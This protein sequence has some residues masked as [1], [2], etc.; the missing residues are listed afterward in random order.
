MGARLPTDGPWRLVAAAAFAAASAIAQ[1]QQAAADADV[2]RGAYLARIGGCAGC[3]TAPKGGAPFA[4]GRVVPSPIGGIFS[5]NI[6]PDRQHGIGDYELQDFERALRA[7][8]ARGGKHLYPAMPYPSYARMSDADVRALFAY[9]RTA[10]APV[11]LPAPR[12]ALPFPFDQRWILRWWKVAFVP[13]GAPALRPDRDAEWQRGAY[14]V[15]TVGHC[16]TCHTPRGLAYQELGYDDT[17]SRYL[18]GAVNDHWLS[19][20]LRA[21]PGAGLARI[22]VRDVASF[23]RTG[24]AAGLVAYGPM[25]DEVEQS[26]QH[27]SASDAM[28]MAR[29]LKSL[30]SQDAQGH[31]AAP[32]GSDPDAAARGL[33]TRDVES[34]GAAVYKGFCAQCHGPDGA[35]LAPAFPRLAGNP[36]LLSDDAS[37]LIRLVLEGG[38][39]PSTTDGPAPQAM[40]PFA[41]TLTDLQIAQVLS[42]TRTRWGNDARQ[43]STQD[44]ASL[45][46]RLRK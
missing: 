8:T 33:R 20:N 13:R 17:S 23:L 11:A 38:R 6:T 12:N 28:A 26:L 14:L 25:A 37:S 21:D 3:H 18:S 7:G 16:G 31:Y 9:L 44:V 46:K 10:V 24:H 36:T 2:A 32:A 30:P 22:D 40:P 35:G 27:L 39:G 5:T 34:V 19:S 42:F 29:Y 1:A 45:R 15:Q 43:V 41:G 4:G